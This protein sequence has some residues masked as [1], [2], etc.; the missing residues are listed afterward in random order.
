MNFVFQI[1]FLT[2]LFIDLMG[3]CMGVYACLYGYDSDVL[4]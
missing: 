1:V 3:E 4:V 2:V